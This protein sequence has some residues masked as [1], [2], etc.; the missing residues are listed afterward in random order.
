M[1]STVRLAVVVGLALGVFLLQY[2]ATSRQSRPNALPTGG[3]LKHTQEANLDL[4]RVAAPSGMLLN[5]PQ[6]ATDAPSGSD[7][8][9]S[10]SSNL[11]VT[12]FPDVSSEAESL[13]QAVAA[14]ANDVTGRSEPVPL[15]GDD[16]FVLPQPLRFELVPVADGED[17]DHAP[18]F[19]RHLESPAIPQSDVGL[20]RTVTSGL[21]G[22]A[23]ISM[24]P[25][26]RVN[27]DSVAGIITNKF[28]PDRG[29]GAD[30]GEH[31]E[32]EVIPTNAQA[33][34]PKLLAASRSKLVAPSL[35]EESLGREV[36]GEPGLQTEEQ[37]RQE[38]EMAPVPDREA[39]DSRQ[40]TRPTLSSQ[41]PNWRPVD[42][43][44]NDLNGDALPTEA[45]SR[46]RGAVREMVSTAFEMAQR[47]AYHSARA[48]FIDALHVVASSLDEQAGATA[49]SSAL[50][51]GLTAYQECADF[52]PRSESTANRVSAHATVLGHETPI[53]KQVETQQLTPGY[54]IRQYMQYAEQELSNALGNDPNA[55]QALYGL[56]RLETQG[57]FS[58]NAASKIQAQ[59]SMLLYQV[60]LIIDDQNFAAANEL[61]VLLARDGRFEQ[62]KD[63]LRHCVRVSPQPT[64]W[65]NL[66]AVHSRLG[67]T[68]LARLAGRE[69]EKAARS[70]HPK[71]TLAQQPRVEWVDTGTFAQINPP[72]E[73]GVSYAQQ[74]TAGQPSLER[75][76]MKP[77]RS[78]KPSWFW[79]SK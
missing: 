31:D 3:S 27:L 26:G 34:A 18:N 25:P 6:L 23:E 5:P 43:W 61:G 40:V 15:A 66:A 16:E 78:D 70:A 71:G 53:L 19:G 56:G 33:T 22:R 9:D 51:R 13:P 73:G 46:D 28:V 76:S 54:C 29:L 45:M 1:G 69:V 72:S 79:P 60:A 63:A 52:L 48:R 24:V 50:K 49:H 62:A 55:S 10:S 2:R 39:T 64:A 59:R 12:A 8:L 14:P 17:E 65:K 67:E 74:R 38:P 35:P 32:R 37:H 30:R 20:E 4:R 7:E 68:R 41:K 57:L 47:K 77:S 75:V 21:P 58:A 11:F 36:A 42:I 44:S